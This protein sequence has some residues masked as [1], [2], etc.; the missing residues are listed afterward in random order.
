M[1]V[2]LWNI[3]LSSVKINLNK[4]MLFCQKL[5]RHALDLMSICLGI[6]NIFLKNWVWQTGK[7]KRAVG[8]QH[9]WSL[10]FI[11]GLSVV[12][13]VHVHKYPCR[14]CSHYELVFNLSVSEFQN[15]AVCS[16]NDVRLPVARGYLY[17]ISLLKVPVQVSDAWRGIC[18]WEASFGG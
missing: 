15:C 1:L 9:F 13:C 8:F 18:N 2:R 16:S 10:I 3:V 7:D 12:F 17:Q 6:V 14:Q 4:Y 11:S 5:Q